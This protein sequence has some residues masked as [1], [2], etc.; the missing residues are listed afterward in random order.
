ANLPVKPGSPVRLSDIGTVRDGTDI[1]TGYALVNGKRTVYMLVTKRSDASSLDVVNNVK[2]NLPRMKQA[3]PEDVDLR[4][5]FDQSPYVTRSIRGVLGEAALGA[6]LTG[7][8]VLLFLRDWRSVIVVVV[9]IPLALLG[10][11][12]AL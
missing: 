8:M 7:L 2:A 11:F 4:L 5:E 6:C 12:V 10:A 1:V 9:N 3:L